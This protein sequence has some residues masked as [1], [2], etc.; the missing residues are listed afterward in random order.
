MAELEGDNIANSAGTGAPNF[1]N[2][3][4]LSGGSSAISG[5]IDWTTWTPVFTFA[6][7]APTPIT[8]LYYAQYMQLNKIVF[9]R[10]AAL[11][12]TRVFTLSNDALNMTL[13][14]VADTTELNIFTAGGVWRNS[15]DNKDWPIGMNFSFNTVTPAI[16]SI[17]GAG[18][19]SAANITNNT[20]SN[21]NDNE[22][23]FINFNYKA[24]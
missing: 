12:G 16:A 9:V 22:A 13:P 21:T 10:V 18:G 5:F 24:M 19:T 15:A 6:A 4:K 17:R 11:L 1:P 3:I 23:Y 14:I 20:A 8:T 2:G 7:N